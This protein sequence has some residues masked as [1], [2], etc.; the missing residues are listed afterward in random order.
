MLNPNLTMADLP[1]GVRAAFGEQDPV[2]VTIP[3]QFRLF[4]LTQYSLMNPNIRLPGPLLPNHPEELFDVQQTLT[5]WW[6]PV[7]PFMEDGLGAVG[8]YMEARANHVTMR[9]MVRFASAVCLD[10]N[11]LDNYLEV[12]TLDS[13]RCFWGD[14]APQRMLSD[15]PGGYQ[16]ALDRAEQ[17]GVH[18]PDT[19]GGIEAYQFYIPNLTI[20]YVEERAS[21]PA[22]DMAA[23]AATLNQ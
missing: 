11:D 5:P 22:H 13:I 19:L 17:R 20:Q 14:Y 9:E 1:G 10:W 12:V 8:R 4:K 23:L 15:N 21:V 3:A 18:V 16:R 2:I 7:F 6:Q